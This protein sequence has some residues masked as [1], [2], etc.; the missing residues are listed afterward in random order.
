M[1]LRVFSLSHFLYCRDRKEKKSAHAAS[2]FLRFHCR[3]SMLLLRS[4]CRHGLFF[5]F[6]RF[7]PSLMMSG[8][9]LWHQLSRLGLSYVSAHV[10]SANLG[11]S[12]R[13]ASMP[14]SPLSSCWASDS[15]EEYSCWEGE[16]SYWLWG[17]SSFL[18]VTVSHIQDLAS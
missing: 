2:S 9:F 12:H 6:F 5:N 18:R 7:H 11:F 1:L 8:T 14:I 3:S 15:R 13:W 4:H 17:S 10:W 16:A